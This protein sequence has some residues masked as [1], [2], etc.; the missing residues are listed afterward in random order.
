MQNFTKNNREGVNTVTREDS[1][2]THCF[3]NSTALGGLQALTAHI[4]VAI[5]KTQHSISP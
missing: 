2:F 5:D 3:N 4:P 1:A